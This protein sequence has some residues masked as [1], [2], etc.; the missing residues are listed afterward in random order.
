MDYNAALAEVYE[1]LNAD[2]VENAVMSCLR[3]ARSANDYLNAAVFLREL[4]SN[5]S[6]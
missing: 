6:L 3:I 4:T 5:D 2:D 1:H